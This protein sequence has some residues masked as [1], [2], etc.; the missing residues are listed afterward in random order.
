MN[1]L[2]IDLACGDRKK[3]G[4]TGVDIANIPEVD[5]VYDLNQYPWPFKDNSVDEIYCSHY[6]EH[7]PHLSVQAILKESN[8]FKEFK[9]KLSNDKDGFIKFF[10]E[11]YRIAKIGGKI[12]IIAPHYMSV[13]AFGDP[14]HCYSE[15]TE[16]LTEEGFKFITEVDVGDKVWTFNK[17]SELNELGTVINTINE[18]YEGDMM[19]FK[20]KNMDILVTPNHDMIYETT[21]NKEE[22]LVWKIN[23]ADSFLNL[24]GDRSRKGNSLF[25]GNLEEI[26]FIEIPYINPLKGRKGSNYINKIP[27]D[28]FCSFLGWYLSEGSVSKVSTGNNGGGI[29]KTEIHQ[30]FDKNKKNCIKIKNLLDEIGYHYN[31]NKNSNRFVIYDKSL[32]YMLKSFGNVY[33]KY[34]PF[35]IKKL[36]KKHLSFLLESLMLGDGRKNGKGFEYASVSKQL[37]D[38]VQEIAIKCGYRSSLYIEKRGY[39]KRIMKNKKKSFCKDIHLVNVYNYKS[40]YIPKPKKINYSGNI[41][42]VT[43]DKNNIV[44]IRRNGTV[45]WSG[46]CRYIGDWS[47]LYLNKEWRDVNKLGHYDI[48]ADFDVTYSYHIDNEL[49]LKS[50]EVRNEA[51][52]KEWNAINDIIVE[53]IKR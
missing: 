15:D 27:T 50:E 31:I 7:I 38:D 47:F 2:K 18:Y 21:K 40:P 17:S 10:N 34:I 1:K 28:L 35:Y 24:K 13:R 9:E 52:R 11:V 6:V 44:L 3:E 16:I 41:A 5:I 37:A 25:I 22:K 19:H 45:L 14:T 49:V 8:S 43:V 30:S 46:N 23:R 36:N 26:E 51:F 48:D 39:F 29:Y 33:S 53:L 20:R 12:T 32:Y 4:F 42:C